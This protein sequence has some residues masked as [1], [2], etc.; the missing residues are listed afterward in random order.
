MI[1]L[2]PIEAPRLSAVDARIAPWSRRQGLVGDFEGRGS[3][4]RRVRCAHNPRK[5]NFLQVN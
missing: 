4:R 5:I 1:T 3:G 2:T